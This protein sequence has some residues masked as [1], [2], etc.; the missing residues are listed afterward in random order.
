MCGTKKDL[1]GQIY[2]VCENVMF[3]VYG[4]SFYRLSAGTCGKH[5]NWSCVIEPVVSNSEL[6][7]LL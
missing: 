4:Y 7:S 6:H 5:L 3:K 1:V 2:K